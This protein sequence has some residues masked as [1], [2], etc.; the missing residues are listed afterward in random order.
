MPA[1]A[2][3]RRAIRDLLHDLYDAPVPAVPGV[4]DALEEGGYGFVTVPQLLAPG[5]AEP[6]RGYRPHGVDGVDRVAGVD[7]VSAAAPDARP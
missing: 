2:R 7:D 3:A 6:G 1:D 4:I 5:K